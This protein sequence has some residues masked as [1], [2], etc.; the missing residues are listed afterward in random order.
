MTRFQVK[1]ASCESSVPAVENQL[2]KFETAVTRVSER[3][4]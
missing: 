2:P 4:G 3:F 1:V